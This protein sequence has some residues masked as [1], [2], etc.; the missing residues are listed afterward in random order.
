MTE[1]AAW[2]EEQVE[3]AVNMLSGKDGC[4]HLSEINL[5]QLL[6]DAMA[7]ADAE[8][9]GPTHSFHCPQCGTQFDPFMYP[10]NRADAHPVEGEYQDPFEETMQQ[11]FSKPAT[12]PHDAHPVEKESD[13]QVER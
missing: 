5:R 10:V 2:R 4:I 8:P 7:V 1:R 11:F 9:H 3:G 12:P 13:E 6:R